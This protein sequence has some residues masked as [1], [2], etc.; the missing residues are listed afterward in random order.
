MNI[1]L[2]LTEDQQHYFKSELK[3]AGHS[4]AIATIRT[5]LYHYFAEDD[6]D[7]LVREICRTYASILR[8]HNFKNN[9]FFYPLFEQD[10]TDAQ[11]SHQTSNLNG[12][13]VN[14]AKKL[15]DPDCINNTNLQHDFLGKVEKIQ[16][17]GSR[18]RYSKIENMD[19]KHF[20]KRDIGS[21]SYVPLP[22]NHRSI[23]NIK[24][25]KIIIAKFG[26]F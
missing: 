7:R 16:L 15:T 12:F 13:H 9:V 8:R 24:I 10:F 6:I 4:F 3:S 19:V 17:N 23:E 5:T 18:W 21:T 14:I 22:T 20:R 11:E 1:P 26:K 25:L 2:T